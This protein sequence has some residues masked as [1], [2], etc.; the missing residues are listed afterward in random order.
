MI[1]T[2]TETALPVITVTIT[3]LC[4]SIKPLRISFGEDF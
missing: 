1:A 2:I 3:N 4:R